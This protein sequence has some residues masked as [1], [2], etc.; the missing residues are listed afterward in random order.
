MEEPKPRRDLI[1]ALSIDDQLQRNLCLRRIPLHR[2]CTYTCCAL[3]HYSNSPTPVFTPPAKP[4]TGFHP[5][6]SSEAFNASCPRVTCSSTPIVIRTTPSQPGSVDRSRSNT[7]CLRI[8][9]TN[10]LCF[11]PIFISKKFAALGKNGTPSSA[12]PPIIRSRPTRTC[13]T[14]HAR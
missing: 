7:P 14:Y 5:I 9:A 13:S 4:L 8:A 11:G 6:S 10:S 3:S 2:S 12:S 1:G